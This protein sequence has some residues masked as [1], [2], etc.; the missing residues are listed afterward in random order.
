MVWGGL[1]Y[2][3]GELDTS[4]LEKLILVIKKNSTVSDPR[5]PNPETRTVIN[6]FVY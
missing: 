1:R 2:F 6:S 3:D 5:T 4:F